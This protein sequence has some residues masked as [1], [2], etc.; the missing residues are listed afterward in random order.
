M[1]L[2]EL[3]YGTKEVDLDGDGRKDLIVRAHRANFNAHSFDT[4]TIYIWTAPEGSDDRAKSELQIVPYQVKTDQELILRTGGGA[5][6]LLEDFRL[7]LDATHH[8][9]VLITAKRDFGKSFADSQPVHFQFYRLSFNPDGAP[10][11]PAVF[12]KAEQQVTSRKTYVD[13]GEAFLEELKLGPGV[14]Q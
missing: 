6:G 2:V 3:R 1:T 4:T 9:A 8:S 14:R 12:F 10:G 13:V 7:L 11:T 5:D